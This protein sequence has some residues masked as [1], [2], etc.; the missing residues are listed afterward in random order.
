[1]EPQSTTIPDG[2]HVNSFEAWIVESDT[3]TNINDLTDDSVDIENEF[4]PF[5]RPSDQALDN[6]GL[7][8]EQAEVFIGK[9]TP[10]A[11][12]QSSVADAAPH[13]DLTILGTSAAVLNVAAAFSC[14]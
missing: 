7:I 6:A 14:S 5:V 4:A 9:K 11:D 10:L 12:W 8:D 2:A 13:V 1:M 3:I